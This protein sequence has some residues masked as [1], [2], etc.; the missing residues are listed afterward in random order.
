MAAGVLENPV[1][2]TFSATL[3]GTSPTAVAEAEVGWTPTAT[4]DVKVSEPITFASAT[5]ASN[6]VAISNTSAVSQ[7]QT[8]TDPVIAD[9]KL[10]ATESTKLSSEAGRVE[11]SI[12]AYENSAIHNNQAAVR[13]WI[14]DWRD[15]QREPSTPDQIAVRA[16]IHNWRDNQSEHLTATQSSAHLVA[17]DAPATVPDKSP[18]HALDIP[19]AGQARLLTGYRQDSASDSPGSWWQAVIAFFQNLW[20]A[21]LSIFR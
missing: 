12:T 3:V 17:A 6:T 21:F 18:R 9:M 20:V 16:W 8:K 14:Q 15:S 5:L 2:S 7:L 11:E 1:N 4:A 13:A 19:S 10:K